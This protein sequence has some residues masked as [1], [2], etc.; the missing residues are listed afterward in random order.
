MTIQRMEKQPT[1]AVSV[2]IADAHLAALASVAKKLGLRRSSA[3]Q[4][5]ISQFIARKGN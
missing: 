1:T 2:R 5:A 3:I 4:L